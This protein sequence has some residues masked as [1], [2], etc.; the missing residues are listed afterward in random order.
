MTPA[1]M[2]DPLGNKKSIYSSDLEK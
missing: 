2:K 1:W